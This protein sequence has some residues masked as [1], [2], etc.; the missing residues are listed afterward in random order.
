[1]CKGRDLIGIA[2]TGTGKTGAFLLP[3]VDRLLEDS[4][5]KALVVVPTREL[6]LQVE[7]EFKSIAKGLNLHSATFIGGTNINRDLNHLKRENHLIV[8]TPGRLNDLILRRA[9]RLDKAPVLVLDE[10]DRMLDMG[11]IRDI[12]KIVGHMTKR[13]QTMLFSA[14]IDHSQKSYIN[15]ILTDPIEIRV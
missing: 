1:M 9:L 2:N 12:K 11:F 6:A 10:F 4:T 8:G 14:T 5:N 3:I 13:R 15:S 7:D